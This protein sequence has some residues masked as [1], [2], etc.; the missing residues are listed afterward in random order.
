MNIVGRFLHKVLEL[1]DQIAAPYEN[2]NGSD[3]E[4]DEQRTVNQSLY[5]LQSTVY[6]V[7]SDS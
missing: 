4:K 3:I 7:S 5:R 2:R 6:T 1:C